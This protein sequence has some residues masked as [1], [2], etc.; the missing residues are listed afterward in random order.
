MRDDPTIRRPIARR[1]MLADDDDVGDPFEDGAKRTPVHVVGRIIARSPVGMW[2][3][4]FVDQCG[5]PGRAWRCVPR[6]SASRS[7]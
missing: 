2:W 5:S 3:C 4:E 1:D 7:A 6:A